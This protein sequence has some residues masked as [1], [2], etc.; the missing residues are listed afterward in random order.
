MSAAATRPEKPVDGRRLR[1]ERTRQRL[2]EAYLGLAFEHAPRVPTSAEIAE[3]ASCSVRSVFERFPDLHKLQ[4]AAASHALD[5]VVALAPPPQ[6]DAEQN[7]RIESHVEMRAHFCEI[8]GRLWQGV[9]VNRADSDELRQKISRF[10]ELRLSRLEVAFGQELAT[11]PN[12]ERRRTLLA[13]GLVTDASS[14]NYMREFLGLSIDEARA[15]WVGAIQ[16]L[17]PS[18]PR[19]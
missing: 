4:V 18:P 15:V 13:L 5:R 7:T 9:L 10:Q 11:L 6:H 14:W 2:V 8:W 3:R 16:R 1:T 12:V 19:V 17:L